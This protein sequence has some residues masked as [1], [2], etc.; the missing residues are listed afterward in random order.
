MRG[1]CT[2]REGQ[3]GVLTLQLQWP[4]GERRVAQGWRRWRRWRRR[5]RDVAAKA[6]V[7]ATRVGGYEALRA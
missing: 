2:R 5:K 1:D 3:A 4:G 6:L 7:L